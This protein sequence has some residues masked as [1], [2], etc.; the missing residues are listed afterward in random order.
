MISAIL[1]VLIVLST[2]CAVL[3]AIYAYIYYTQINPRSHR[4][5]SYIEPPSQED[6]P[7]ANQTTTHTHMFLFRKS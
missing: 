2:L 4:A 3:G 7:P 6:D 5:R 1:I